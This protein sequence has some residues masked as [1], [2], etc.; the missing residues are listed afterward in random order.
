M[1]KRKATTDTSC[2]DGSIA[3]ALCAV[4][5]ANGDT[6]TMLAIGSRWAGWRI[7]G[8]VCEPCRKA[9]ARPMAL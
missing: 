9:L 8:N 1:D 4:V 6:Y 5:V 2:G 7:V 3:C